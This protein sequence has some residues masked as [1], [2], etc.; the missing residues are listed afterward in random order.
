MTHSPHDPNDPADESSRLETVALTTPQDLLSAI[1]YLLGFQP[2]HGLVVLGLSQE[3]RLVVTVSADLPLLRETGDVADGI[4]RCLAQ[5]ATATVMVVGYCPHH[6]ASTLSRFA[7][8]L[9]WQVRELLLVS[10]QRWWSLACTDSGCCP[11]D[12]QPVIRQDRIAAPL[13]ATAGAPA[14]SRQ[15]LAASLGAG[16]G[17]VV[18]R[19]RIHLDAARTSGGTQDTR[20][21]YVA[22]AQARADRTAG[23]AQLSPEQAASLLAAL[24]DRTVMR[25]AGL[26]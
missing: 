13:L 18:D 4:A 16:P 11:S 1:P 2:D 3:E 20:A 21:G 7:D 9:P 23:S 15:A 24:R 22:L 8:L 17:D 19:V 25:W 6:K 26:R 12:G 14:L 5:V 10:D